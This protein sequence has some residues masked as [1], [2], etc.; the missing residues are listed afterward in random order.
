M[1][2]NVRIFK[3]LLTKTNK[4]F[5]IPKDRNHLI[6]L[7]SPFKNLPFWQ[8]IYVIKETTNKIYYG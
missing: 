4:G 6:Y 3:S 7:Y 8:E 5:H 1:T 2:Y